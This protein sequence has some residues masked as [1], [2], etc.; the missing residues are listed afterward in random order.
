[1]NSPK[2]LLVYSFMYTYRSKGWS[3]KWFR[4]LKLWNTLALIPYNTIFKCEIINYLKLD[5]KLEFVHAYQFLNSNLVLESSKWIVWYILL[6]RSSP[7]FFYNFQN[8]SNVIEENYTLR[9]SRLFLWKGIPAINYFDVQFDIKHPLLIYSIRIT[10]HWQKFIK[11]GG[12]LN[13][14]RNVGFFIIL[15]WISIT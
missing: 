5:L 2:F 10:A 6:Y 1:M 12:I 4:N 14:G 15:S 13:D 8:Y 9:S 7:Y 3:Q 11:I